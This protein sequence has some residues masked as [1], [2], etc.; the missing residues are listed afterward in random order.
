MYIF[1]LKKKKDF[2]KGILINFQ[3]LKFNIKLYFTIRKKKK[4][5]YIYIY[6]YAFCKKNLINNQ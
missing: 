3:K 6:I 5:I 4:N 2:V 1:F